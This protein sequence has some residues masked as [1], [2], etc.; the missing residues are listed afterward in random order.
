MAT[1]AVTGSAGGIGTA[2]RARL[3]AAG[4]RVIGIDLTDAEVI[5]DLATTEGRVSAIAEVTGA[6][7]GVLDGLVVAA[8]IANGHAPTLVSVNFFGAVA[9]LDGLRPLLARGTDSSVVALSSNSTTTQPGFPVPLAEMCLAGDEDGARVLAGDDAVSAYPATKLALAR[10]VRRHATT[11]DWIGAGIRLTAIAPGFT[12]TPMTAGMWEFVSSIGDIFPIP[13]GRPGRPE[14]IA[15]LIA[16][17]LSADAGFMVGS[18]ITV[19]G[20]TEAALRPDDWPR[21]IA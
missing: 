5:A 14:E 1:I 2:T 16:Y 19:D 6:C 21:P 20:G 13:V 7:G 17:L 9:T 11:P 8:G 15:S 10:W 3:E 12:D 18:F 4:D